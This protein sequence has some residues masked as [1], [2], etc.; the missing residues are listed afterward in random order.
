MSAISVYFKTKYKGSVKIVGVQPAPNEVVPGIRRIE[1]GMK[2]YHK[3]SFDEVLDVKQAEAIEG[4]MKIAKKEG[5]L[6]GLSA[7]AVVHAFQKIAEEK[8][9]YVLVFPDSGYKYA[10]Q[11]EK[12]LSSEQS[13]TKNLEK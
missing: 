6:I 13:P 4:A 11:F 10:E 8:G 5:L 3:A 7:G 1:T 9:V 12:Y 2:W